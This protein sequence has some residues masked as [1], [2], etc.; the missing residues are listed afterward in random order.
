MLRADAVETMRMHTRTTLLALAT[1]AALLAASPV[2]VA[3][4]ASAAAHAQVGE[5]HGRKG[6]GV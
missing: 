4:D 6:A 1:F 2:A 3:E 5:N